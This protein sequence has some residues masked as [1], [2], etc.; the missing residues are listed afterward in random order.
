MEAFGFDIKHINSYLNKNFIV[1]AK[2]Y[3]FNLFYISYKNEYIRKIFLVF[4][5]I[6][7]YIIYIK[8]FS[9]PAWCQPEHD[10]DKGWVYSTAKGWHWYP[11]D[12]FL[13]AKPFQVVNPDLHV[14]LNLSLPPMREAP[15]G[16]PAAIIRTYVLQDG[17]PQ[18]VI[19][20]RHPQ[21]G[22]AWWHGNAQ[23]E[24]MHNKLKAMIKKI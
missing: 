4:F 10:P 12:P 13:C 8:Y 7:I 24:S 1:S 5:I 16:M 6:I 22:Y 21:P 11:K 23:P 17:V 18:E 2:N 3:V 15:D 9:T 19:V 14:N 20:P